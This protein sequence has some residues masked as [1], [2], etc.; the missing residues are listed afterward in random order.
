MKKVLLLLAVI[1][2]AVTASIA[3]QRWITRGATEGELYLST[4]W[5]CNYGFDEDTLY[6]AILHITENGQK[7]E[8][9]YGG[10][11]QFADALTGADLPMQI[12]HIMADATPGV[13]YNTDWY[14]AYSD[15]QPYDFTRL[16]F[17]EDYGKTW[18]LRDTPVYQSGYV[19][20]C[21]EGVLYRGGGAFLKV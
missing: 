5:Y 6:N 15:G 13:L 11:F 16:W 17:S 9:N 10:M 2:S 7:A 12:Y 4:Q 20:G 18:E 21:D 14:L 1:L 8:I 3:Q 19:T